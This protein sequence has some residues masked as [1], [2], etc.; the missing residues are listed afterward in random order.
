MRPKYAAL[1]LA[2]ALLLGLPLP[3]WGGVKYKVLRSFGSGQDGAGPNGPLV[4][5]SRDLYGATIGGGDG[6]RGGCGTVFELAP[7]ADG[8]WEETVLYNFPG[9]D[10]SYPGGVLALDRAGD[11]YGTMAG[12]EGGVFELSPS[13]GGYS[14][15]ALY[16]DSAGPG[17]LMDKLGN[18]YGEIGPGQLKAGAIG[19]LSSG[20]GG[21]DYTQLYSF[22]SGNSCP[23]GVD[24]PTPP[25]WDGKGNMFGT[26]TAGGIYKGCWM[27]TS[28]CGV[29][30]EMTPDG[31]G[32]WTYHVLH[33]FA[34][35]KTDGQTPR[36]GLVMDAAGNFYGTTVLGGTY[37]NG[38]VFKLSHASGAW[39]VTHLYDFPDCNIGCVP[40]GTLAIDVEGNLY[41]T[42]SGGLAACGGY[43]CG[44]VFKMSPEKGG[45]WTYRVLHKL[46]ATDG[47]FPGYGVILN[48]KGHLFGVTSQFGKYGGGTAFEITP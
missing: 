13:S 35:F 16:T 8:A 10:Y 31:D 1:T 42:A 37:D 4:L 48:G 40:S 14:F 38:I 5:D 29:I 27:Y 45:K 9:G 36:G 23:D 30:Y 19:E 21:W 7:R 24:P 34:S 39:K 22:C 28:G 26:T 3:A 43:D 18:L 15:S 11:I 17:L 12:Y 6:C 25:I 44:V 41:G 47:G 46:T 2:A 32:T 20:S 33:R